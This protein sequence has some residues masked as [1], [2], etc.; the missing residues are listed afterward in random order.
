MNKIFWVMAM[1]VGLIIPAFAVDRSSGCGLG[2][3]IAPRK[4]LLST[5]TAATTD[6]VSFPTQPS[7][8]TS[9]TSG[10]APHGLLIEASKQDHFISTNIAALKLESAIG[11]GEHLATLGQ[12]YGCSHRSGFEQTIKDNYAEIFADDEDAFLIRTKI[13]STVMS[14]RLEGC[15]I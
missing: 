14:N 3:M 2:R 6:G 7:A 1:I 13:Q 15:R 8:M 10:C 9:G 5:S 4:S 12:F 11:Q